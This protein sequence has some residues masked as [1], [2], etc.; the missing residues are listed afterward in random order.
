MIQSDVKY[1]FRLE[2]R[3]IYSIIVYHHPICN[4]SRCVYI[5]IVNDLLV[6]LGSWYGDMESFFFYLLSSVSKNWNI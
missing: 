6:P 5:W 1:I 2:L 4:I 3:T